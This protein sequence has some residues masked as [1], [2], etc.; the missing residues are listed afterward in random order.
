L[1][2]STRLCQTGICL[3]SRP[4]FFRL[5]DLFLF[6][7]YKFQSTFSFLMWL[8][9]MEAICSCRRITFAVVY[10]P[11]GAAPNS[12]SIS[13]HNDL[14]FNLRS[15]YFHAFL[16]RAAVRSVP[17][18]LTPLNFISHSGVLIFKCALLKKKT[19]CRWYI[20]IIIILL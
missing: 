11:A 6:L 2:N 20:Y 8:Q 10:A 19:F 4:Q 18:A 14:W 12:C 9:D 3:V 13:P 7:I 1:A 5:N 17:L 15:R 16:L